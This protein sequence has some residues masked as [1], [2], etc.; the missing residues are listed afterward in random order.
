MAPDQPL[1][2]T[3]IA[4]AALPPLPLNLHI[5]QARAFCGDIIAISTEDGVAPG[6]PYILRGGQGEWERLTVQ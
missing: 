2:P 4:I 3:E 1:T 6:H 5:L